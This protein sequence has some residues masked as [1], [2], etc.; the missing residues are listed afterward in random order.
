MPC[1]FT[2][3]GAKICLLLFIGFPVIQIPLTCVI[4][5]CCRILKTI[6]RITIIIII[7]IVIIITIDNALF[8]VVLLCHFYNH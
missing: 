8:F 3:T 4:L 2:V 6:S 7:M 1:M 5:F